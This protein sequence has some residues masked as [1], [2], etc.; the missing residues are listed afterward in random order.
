MFA[1]T[2]VY[3]AE[4]ILGRRSDAI[5]LGSIFPDIMT[6]AGVEHG[7]AH[8]LGLELL[9]MFT[10]SEELTDFALAAITHGISPQGLDYFGDEK[11][12]GFERGYCFEKGRPLVR[13]TIAA[14]N[15]PENMGLWK[16]HNIVEMGI[17]TKISRLDQYGQVLRRAF[18]NQALIDRLIAAL[19]DL[20]GDSER[21]K[22]RILA[23]PG[24]IG[25]Q[26]AT[27]ASMAQ[28]YCIQMY[29]KHQININTDQVTEL[30]AIAA[31][32]V[33]NDLADFFHLTRQQ[34]QKE[35]NTLLNT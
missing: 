26:Q 25:V 13:Q 32:A 15:L 12:P 8:S 1:Q 27:P 5:T 16:A 33:E 21:L 17:E 14:C 30:I 23:F 24:Y 18:N 34:V 7:R 22:K 35:I 6:G 10:D 31:D 11:Y 19:S 3:F 9:R 4:A 2:H 20:T 29:T 28:I